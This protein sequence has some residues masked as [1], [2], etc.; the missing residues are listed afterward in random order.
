[1][2][3]TILREDE[4]RMCTGMDQEAVNAVALGFTRLVEGKVSLPL[5]IRLPR[6]WLDLPKEI[7]IDE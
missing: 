2:K 1:M 6:I 4:I 5:I 7:G 3:V